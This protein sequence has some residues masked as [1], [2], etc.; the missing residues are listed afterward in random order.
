MFDSIDFIYN[1]HQRPTQL[2]Q[3]EYYEFVFK[4]TDFETI[5]ENED[6]L[7][8]VCI[9]IQASSMI[10]TI[11]L[12]LLPELMIDIRNIINEINEEHRQQNQ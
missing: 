2:N 12:S 9:N 8:V 5:R 3:Y 10:S 6:Y 1:P 7:Q 11:Q 4:P